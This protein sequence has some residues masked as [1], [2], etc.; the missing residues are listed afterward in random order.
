MACWR[1]RC[2][3]WLVEKPFLKNVGIQTSSTIAETSAERMLREQ[4]GVEQ[5]S[6]IVLVNQ[7]DEL[8]RKTKKIERELEKYKKQ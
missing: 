8:K 7:V 3:Q 6:F 4:L 5:E 2:L 1:G